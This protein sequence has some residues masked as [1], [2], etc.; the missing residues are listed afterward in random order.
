MTHARPVVRTLRSS[1]A[2][3]LAALPCALHAAQAPES[4][5]SF[6]NGIVAVAEE[7]AITVDDIRREIMP[8]IPALQR[9]ARNE[10][11]FNEKLEAL[12][13]E[14]I[15]DQID[16]VLIVKDFYKEKEGEGKR[17]IPASYIDNQLAETIITQFDNDRSKFLAHL[18]RQGKTIREF[19]RELEEDMIYGY[20][21][22][23]QRKSQSLISPFK[24]ETYYNENKDR[25]FQ[26]DQVHLR[27]I[28]FNRTPNSTDAELSSK[29]EMVYA[30]LKGGESFAD[31]AKEISQDTR[32]SRGGDW[33]WQK[34][35]DLRPELSDPV[36]ALGKGEVT[37]PILM[38]EG[39]F[40]LYV[41]DRKFAGTQPLDEVR[42]EIERILVQQMARSSQERWLERLRR[43]GYVK[44]F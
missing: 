38:A 1:L 41:E 22:S 35:G 39:A 10:K 17:S 33:G 14:K 5:L 11:E 24:V 37:R 15:Q 23:Q 36:F 28:Q 19:R 31:I 16:R 8:L 44:H 26:D 13:D 29:A 30:R 40:I 7:K 20:M 27:L 34:R 9:E 2:F 6:A 32:R 18:R 12:Q 43:N 21:R 4:N 25:F 42:D 3:V